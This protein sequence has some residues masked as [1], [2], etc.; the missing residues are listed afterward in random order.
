MGAD[1]FTNTNPLDARFV[2]LGDHEPDWS[3]P[4]LFY[5]RV[6]VQL[7]PG[8]VVPFHW[9]YVEDPKY[10]K[11]DTITTEDGWLMLE[12]PKPAS[13][14]YR[15]TTM[16]SDSIISVP[17]TVSDLNGAG[18]TAARFEATLD[19]SIFD[20]ISVTPGPTEQAT[21]NA[22]LTG[23]RIT[24]DLS[25]TGTSTLVGNT[26]LLFVQ[27]HAKHRQDTVCSALTDGSLKPLNS[28]A[29]LGTVSAF[30]GNICVY[31]VKP[32]DIVARGSVVQLEVFPNPATSVVHLTASEPVSEVQV[33]DLL[34][35]EVYSARN[36]TDW[37]PSPSLANGCYHLIA[38][39]REGVIREADVTLVR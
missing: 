30:F 37:S 18:L 39:D 8:D 33:Y 1:A 27:L 31:G 7:N 10:F 34:G 19:T 32:P 24:A 14:A 36:I 11:V 35:H 5:V 2:M 29:Y 20:F 26:T 4:I 15:D 12:P 3:N 23:S 9:T 6:S 17:V 22:E 16:R 38:R 28:G 21:V 25:A 13:I